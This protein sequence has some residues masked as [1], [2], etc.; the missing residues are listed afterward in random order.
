MSAQGSHSTQEERRPLLEDEGN[1]AKRDNGS[2]ERQAATEQSNGQEQEDDAS[3]EDETS[4]AKLFV[5]FA[6]MWVGVSQSR[7]IGF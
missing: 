6:S 5:I 1:G 2:I 7:G 4:S 3:E